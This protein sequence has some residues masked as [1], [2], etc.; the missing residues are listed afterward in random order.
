MFDSEEIFTNIFHK[1]GWRGGE[2]ISGKGSGLDQTE[3]IRK[4]LPRLFNHLQIKSILDCPCGDCQW[5]QFIS[6]GNID[7]IGGDIVFELVKQNSIKYDGLWFL[8]M[9]ILEAINLT[10][11][12]ILCRDCLV[13]FSDT[14]ILKAL[15][16]IKESKSKYLLTTCFPRKQNEPDIVTGKG[17]RPINLCLPPFNLPV[18]E[19]VINENCPAK[20]F[21]DKCLYLWNLETIRSSEK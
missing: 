6:L 18:P 3:K 10:V 7:Y 14:D 5:I 1:N 8:H 13:H 9:S 17:W 12:L 16:N 11:D 4:E 19:S 2:S 20:G 15:K 21:S